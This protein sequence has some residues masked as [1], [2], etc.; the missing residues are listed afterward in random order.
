MKKNLVFM[1]IAVFTL[2]FIAI[3]SKVSAKVE[4][5]GLKDVIDEEVELF[6]NA[7]G[8]G[9]QVDQLK[10]ADLSNYSENKDK[11]N[12]YLFRGN[13]CGHCFDAVVFFSSIVEEY[14]DRFNLIAYEVWGNQD[15]S[16]VMNAV[17]SKL[18]DEVGGVP[19]IVVGNK[20]WNGYTDS[21]GDEIKKAIDKEYKKD[22]SDR[23]DVIKKI[24]KNTKSKSSSNDVVSLLIIILVT[25]GVVAGIVYARKHS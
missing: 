2:S 3:P 22:P 13:T 15:N 10:N 14:G 11:V 16:E 6:Q 7:D 24:G 20:S 1:I 21:Y 8:Y 18:G 25:A 9:E 23:Y 4:V 12:V 5:T 19:Y 17:A